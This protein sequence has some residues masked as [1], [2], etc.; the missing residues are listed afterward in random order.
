M[1]QASNM[2]APGRARNEA[3][4]TAGPGTCDGQ[5]TMTGSGQVMSGGVWSIANDEEFERAVG[6]GE[7][8]KLSSELNE[9]NVRKEKL[10]DTP[11]LPALTVKHNVA[12]RE[13]ALVPPLPGPE[14]GAVPSRLICPGEISAV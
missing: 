11:S 1:P 5:F 13:S 12:S 3:R 9:E 2:A 14:N 4:S 10:V 8:W 6:T 7:P